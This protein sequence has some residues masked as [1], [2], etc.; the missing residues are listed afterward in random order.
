LTVIADLPGPAYQYVRYSEN[1]KYFFKSIPFYN[2]DLTDF[3]KTVIYNAKTKKKLYTIENYLPTEAF[4]SNTG[5]TLITTT[6]WMWDHSEFE[7]QTLVKIY[8]KN[9]DTIQYYIDDLISDKSKLQQTVSHTLWYQKMFVISDTLNILTI[10]NNVVR[11]EMITGKIVETIQEKDCSNC[12]KLD[13][14]EDPKTK[15]YRKIKYPE[16]YVFP[17]LKSGQSF[18]ES[19]IKGLHKTEVEE[20]SECKYYIMVYGAIDKSGSCEIFMLRAN[21]DEKENDKWRK[22]V[23]DWVT[24]QKYK[25]NLIPKNCD[26]WVFQEYFY[27]K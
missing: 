1:G 9:R 6:Y 10:D 2:Y 3:G 27:L 18:R 17:D 16:G 22:Q 21:V 14:L 7:K 13:K 11:I 20:Y 15:Y 24:E 12:T 25:T 4:I 26:K 8:I 23:S 19:L 5:K